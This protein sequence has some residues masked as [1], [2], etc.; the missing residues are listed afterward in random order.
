MIITV[1]QVDSAIQEAKNHYDN[2]GK[3]F[4]QQKRY[5]HVYNNLKIDKENYKKVRDLKLNNEKEFPDG[6]EWKHLGD[7]IKLVYGIYESS[8]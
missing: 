5:R 4:T 7:A 8:A 1:D 3:K 6:D 2:C